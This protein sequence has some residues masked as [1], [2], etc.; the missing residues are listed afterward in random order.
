M[1]TKKYVS[2]SD[3]DGNQKGLFPI[4]FQHLVGPTSPQ[5]NGRQ[6]TLMGTVVDFGAE[7][8]SQRRKWGITVHGS[9]YGLVDGNIVYRA[10]GAAFAA[11][12]ATETGNKW[13]RNFALAVA[14]G[15]G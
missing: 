8:T 10:A 4:H 12:D 13:Y 11:E 14:W 9:H 3:T 7:N 2:P 15:N 1:R 6:F 5:S